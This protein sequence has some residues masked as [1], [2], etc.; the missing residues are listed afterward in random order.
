VVCHK[1]SLKKTK[2]ERHHWIKFVRGT[3]PEERAE[4]A[5]I[6][7]AAPTRPLCSLPW[8]YWPGCLLTMSPL[9][10]CH[11]LQKL[12]VFTKIDSPCMSG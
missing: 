8:L 10:L 6:E 7:G 4:Q 11:F 5:G 2:E 9:L 1:I 3:M 12:S